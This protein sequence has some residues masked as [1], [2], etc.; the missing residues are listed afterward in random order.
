MNN[1][2]TSNKIQKHEAATIICLKEIS[3]RLNVLLGQNEC[4]NYLKSTIS[5]NIIMRYPGEY[6]FPGGV[7]EK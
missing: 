2:N 4:I 7:V 5:T 6:K 3:G 1:E